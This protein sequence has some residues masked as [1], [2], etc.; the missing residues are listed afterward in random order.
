MVSRG[1]R[2]C[3]LFLRLTPGYR[4][5][6]DDYI[7]DCVCGPRGIWDGDEGRLGGMVFGGGGP[8]GDREANPGLV[9]WSVAKSNA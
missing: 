2:L 1:P 6:R 3:D 4:I 8:A 7:F 5:Q 9:F